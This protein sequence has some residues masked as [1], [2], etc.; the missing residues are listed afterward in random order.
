LA[1]F[2]VHNGIILIV[3]NSQIDA[4]KIVIFFNNT[5]KNGGKVQK[6]IKITK[7]MGNHAHVFDIFTIFAWLN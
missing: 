7:N 5:K 4:A 6:L 3:N 2:N 1:L